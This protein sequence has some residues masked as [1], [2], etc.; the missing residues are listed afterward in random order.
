MPACYCQS[1][2]LF[3]DAQSHR[4]GLFLGGVYRMANH[5]SDLNAKPL[6][7]NHHEIRRAGLSRPC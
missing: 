5:L 1:L 3:D 6:S 7:A 4:G 2:S